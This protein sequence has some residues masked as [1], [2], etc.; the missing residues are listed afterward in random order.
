MATVAV[1]AVPIKMGDEVV[2]GFIR[3]KRIEGLTEDT[4]KEHHF[5][6]HF[7]T[8]MFHDMTREVDVFNALLPV[9]R[10]ELLEIVRTNAE[11]EN[12]RGMYCLWHM[13]CVMA[14][15]FGG[16]QFKAETDLWATDTRGMMPA[17]DFGRVLSR[18]KFKRILR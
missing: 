7:K 8:N 1:G 2:A 5:D 13:D 16:A 18:D 10:E 12:D 15:I 3:W 17:P 14:L 11:E 6:T 4:R 9:G